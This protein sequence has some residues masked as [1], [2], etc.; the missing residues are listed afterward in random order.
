MLGGK[1]DTLNQLRLMEQVVNIEGFGDYSC[2]C[3]WCTLEVETEEDGLPVGSRRVGG[4][5]L[6]H[7]IPSPKVETRVSKQGT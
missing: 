2:C 7:S 4:L 5:Q 6:F 1:L 3:V